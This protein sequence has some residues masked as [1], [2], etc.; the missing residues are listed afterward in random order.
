MHFTIRTVVIV[1][2]ARMVV[3]HFTT[4]MV[5]IVVTKGHQTMMVVLAVDLQMFV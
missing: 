3:L 1:V 2:T 4:R 5:V